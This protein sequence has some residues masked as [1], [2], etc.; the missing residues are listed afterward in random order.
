MAVDQ[1]LIQKKICPEAKGESL[2]RLLK[3]SS[4]VTEQKVNQMYLNAKKHLE[5]VP[6]VETEL[7]NIPKKEKNSNN[8]NL[9]EIIQKQESRIKILEEQMEKIQ[10]SIINH[11]VK[12][13][14]TK[15]AENK[16]QNNEI[17]AK[18]KYVC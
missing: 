16:K 18:R 15:P 9:L 13:I 6:I 12:N 3:D 5:G 4:R 8:Y 11:Q 1:G 2:R 14:A 17:F 7:K 10:N